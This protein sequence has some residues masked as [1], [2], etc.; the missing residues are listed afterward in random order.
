MGVDY[1]GLDSW[2]I[3]LIVPYHECTQASVVT[4]R[5]NVMALAIKD[6]DEVT[7]QHQQ[8]FEIETKQRSICFF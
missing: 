5:I 2:G 8:A 4:G 3:V 7:H 1:W 6:C